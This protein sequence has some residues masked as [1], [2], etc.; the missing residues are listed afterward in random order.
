MARE[1]HVNMAS[2]FD[3]SSAGLQGKNA[4]E[5]LG[6]VKR[7]VDPADAIRCATMNAAELLGWEDRVG[8]IEAG[9]YADVI[10]VE[11]DPLTDISALQH[12]Q[13]VMKGG[14]VKKDASMDAGRDRTR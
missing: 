4:E 9:K 12:V 10:G 5:L 13:F 8:V 7:G 1:L 2:G 3:A 6:L 11:G 14:K